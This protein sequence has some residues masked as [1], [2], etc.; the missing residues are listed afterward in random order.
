MKDKRI[1][2]SAKMLD[3]WEKARINFGKRGFY[4]LLEKKSRVPYKTLYSAFCDKP[5]FP[6]I[7]MRIDTAISNLK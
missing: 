3:S 1:K 7:I 6:I 5:Q 4:A 2:I